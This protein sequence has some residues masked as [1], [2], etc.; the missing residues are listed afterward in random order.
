M[1]NAILISVN[2][3]KI[4]LKKLEIFLK[5][6]YKFYWPLTRMINPKKFK[7]PLSCYI[8]VCKRQ[9]EYKMIIKK[10]I[11]YSKEFLENISVQKIIS[12]DIINQFK[13]LEEDDLDKKGMMIISKISPLKEPIKTNSLYTKNNVRIKF[14]PQHYYEII[15]PMGK[16]NF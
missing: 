2:E 15:D 11:P 9:T 8:H 6:N 7:F 5:V 1:E 12:K 14:A 13:D 3:E 4:N 10:I 16:L